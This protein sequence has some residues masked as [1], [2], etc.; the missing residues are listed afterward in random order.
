VIENSEARGVNE[1][2]EDEVAVGCNGQVNDALYR[3]AV[4]LVKSRADYQFMVPFYDMMNHHNSLVNVAHR[5]NPYSG[6]GSD[7]IDQTG[8][9]IVTT[10]PITASE[11]LFL[12]YNH[13]NICSEYVDWFGTP[14]MFLH[15]GFVEPLPQ[16]WLFDFARVKF[17]LDYKDGDESSGEVIVRFL[18]PPSEKGIALL[19][20][21]LTRLESFSSIHKNM[22][23]ESAGISSSEWQSLWQY[24]NALHDA[25]SHAVQHSTHVQLTEDVWKLDDDWWVQDGTLSAADMD[26]HFVYPTTALDYL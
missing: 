4:M 14:E 12:S 26:E 6:L 25:L 2:L 5:Y 22:N 21:E 9:E 8:Y 16:R 23:Y 7:P 20:E 10:K 17:D 13:G 19:Q 15:F 24:F 18:V 11:Q 3:H 1:L